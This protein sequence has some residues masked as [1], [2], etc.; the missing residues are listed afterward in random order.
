MSANAQLGNE[1]RKSARFVIVIGSFVAVV[2]LSSSAV[3]VWFFYRLVQK[4]VT[5]KEEVKGQLERNFESILRFEGAVAIQ[6]N[7][8]VKTKAQGHVSETYK[9]SSDYEI[10]KKHYDAELLKQGW[11]FA[12]ER[13]VIYDG[14]DYGGKHV[15][16]CKN[17]MT[18]N[19]QHAG[20]QEEEFGWTYSFAVAIGLLNECS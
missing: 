1:A 12:R 10:I 4:E 16:Y 20:R 9:T 15:F 3:A 17:N 8:L 5:Y 18:A 11:S 2:L 19:L 14:V 7:S 13:K 6:R